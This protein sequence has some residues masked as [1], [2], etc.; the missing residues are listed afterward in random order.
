MRICTLKIQIICKRDLLG[1]EEYNK[2][3]TEVEAKFAE[4]D[5]QNKEPSNIIIP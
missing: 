4:M 1:E 3:V 2:M 5:K